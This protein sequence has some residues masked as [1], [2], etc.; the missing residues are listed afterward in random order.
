MTKRF[1]TPDEI[2]HILHDLPVP[3]FLP[4]LIREAV[5]KDIHT[6]FRK[7]LSK[8]QV[9]PQILSKIKECVHRKYLTS[10]APTGDM[11]GVLAS[12]SMESFT[13]MTLNMF[14][15][16]GLSEKNVSLGLPRFEELM[17]ATSNPKIIGWNFYP[18]EKF[19]SSDK[20]RGSILLPEVKLGNLITRAVPEMNPVEDSWYPL[21]DILYS[22]EYKKCTWRVRLFM[23]PEK[24]FR[25]SLTLV[26]IASEIERQLETTFVVCSPMGG[27]KLIIDVYVDT[28]QIVADGNFSELE[29]QEQYVRDIVLKALKD[30]CISGVR[31]VEAVYPKQTKTGEWYYEGNGGS[32]IDLLSHPSCNSSKT[33]NDNMWDIFECLGI[34]ATRAFLISEIVK[35]LSFDGTFVNPK[36]VMLLVDRMTIDGNISAVNRYGMD[37]EHF[38]PLAKMAFEES[39]E[40][41]LRS[42]IHGET[43][44]LRGVNACIITGKTANIG[45]SSCELLVDLAQLEDVQEETS[46]TIEF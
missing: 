9:Y 45:G 37:R 22:K 4:P 42:A 5:T 40:N 38:G 28:V 7:Q 44:D 17:N 34:E 31:G 29:A 20:L 1:L 27:D 39:T 19:D 43:D 41:T 15:S 30:L 26:Q 23:N 3:K 33:V 21:H 13:Q 11:V 24:I 10:L 8:M 46:D 25:Q 36:H 16:A 35:V 18:L 2:A 12:Q 14:H 32:L 6:S